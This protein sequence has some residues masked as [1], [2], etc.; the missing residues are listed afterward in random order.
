MEKLKKKVCLN[1]TDLLL[2]RLTS[3]WRTSCWNSFS[4]GIWSAIVSI[5]WKYTKIS[6]SSLI[7][8]ATSQW[9][10][11]N[12]Y[13]VTQQYTTEEHIAYQHITF[14]YLS[15]TV[16]GIVIVC[17]ISAVIL[18][19]LWVLLTRWRSCNQH[20]EDGLQDGVQELLLQ[21]RLQSPEKR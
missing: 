16:F 14:P 7:F 9:K 5:I 4:G 19:I 20:R 8:L 12:V 10:C 6:S 21:H 11:C 13:F 15:S 17:A 3:G 2:F 1:I 18:L